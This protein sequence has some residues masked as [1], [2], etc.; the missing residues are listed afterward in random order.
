MSVS[1][2]IYLVGFMTINIKHTRDF[3]QPTGVISWFTTKNI[4]GYK[5]L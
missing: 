1:Q 5:M 4:N 2:V 3:Q